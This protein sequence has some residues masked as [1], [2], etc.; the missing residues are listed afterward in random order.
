MFYPAPA[1]HEL[2]SIVDPMTDIEV[3][4]GVE[5]GEGS[6][7]DSDDFEDSDD[8]T[9]TVETANPPHQSTR[10]N[11]GVPPARCHDE[12]CSVA[13]SL[14]SPMRSTTTARSFTC[15]NHLDALSDDDDD[16]EE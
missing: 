8:D 1:C 2:T 7:E 4:E 13:R 5:V 3:K 6:N 15:P 14:S 12:A 10:A 11:C 16:E 9:V